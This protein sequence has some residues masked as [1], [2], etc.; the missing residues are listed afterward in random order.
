MYGYGA[1]YSSSRAVAP[2]ACTA[3]LKVIVAELEGRRRRS[4]GP[5]PR[6]PIPTPGRLRLVDMGVTRTWDALILVESDALR[7]TRSSAPCRE[8][9]QYDRGSS[10]SRSLIRLIR[11]YRQPQ[12]AQSW[13]CWQA[14]PDSLRWMSLP[15]PTTSGFAGA[16]EVRLRAAKTSPRRR[17]PSPLGSRHWI[18]DF[19]V[20]SG[21]WMRYRATPPY[22]RCWCC[23]AVT[24]SLMP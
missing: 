24:R 3:L 2:P 9:P 23:R 17:L 12:G 22:R 14:S 4:G 15:S 11:W 18:A 6:P 8:L 21:R 1:A 16:A 20:R 10:N 5:S 13:R 19:H 7:S